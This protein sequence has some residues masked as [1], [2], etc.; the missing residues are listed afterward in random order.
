MLKRCE[1]MKNS[2]FWVVVLLMIGGCSKEAGYGGLAEI[3]GKIFA[4]DVTSSGIL[5]AEGYLGDQRVYISAHDNPAY[6]DNV[7]T[8]YDGSYSFK[9]LQKG[10]Y[11]IWAFSDCDTCIWKQKYSIENVTISAKKEV[12]EVGDIIIYF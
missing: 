3:K 11:D 4:K 1:K 7:R 10:S 5:K 2:V 12:K 6:F 9:F 8:S